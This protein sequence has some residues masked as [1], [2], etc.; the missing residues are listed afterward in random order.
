VSKAHLDLALVGLD[1]DDEDQ[2]VVLP[3]L[4]CRFCIQG[5]AVCMECEKGKGRTNWSSHGVMATGR[6]SQSTQG[7]FAVPDGGVDAEEENTLE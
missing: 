6:S 2:G 3:N 7:C 4:H 1:V 5:L